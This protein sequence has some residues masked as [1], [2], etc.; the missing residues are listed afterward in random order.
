VV[1]IHRVF[2]WLLGVIGVAL[3]TSAAVNLATGEAAPAAVQ[4]V[5]GGLLVA[6]VYIRL[7]YVVPAAAREA[8]RPRP[9]VTIRDHTKGSRGAT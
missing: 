7:R 2:A 1:R 3:L 4:V 5:A 9:K 6:Y 8:A